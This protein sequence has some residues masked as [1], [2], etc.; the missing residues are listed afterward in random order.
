MNP[1][2]KKALYSIV[3]GAAV[4]AAAN[5]LQGLIDLLLDYKET[6]IPTA[7]GMLHYLRSS[8]SSVVV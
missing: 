3:I 8:R 4:V 2:L 5:I 7:T 6:L 1:E